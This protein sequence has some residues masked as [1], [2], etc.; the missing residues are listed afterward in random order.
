MELG[1]IRG[2]DEAVD[3]GA[4]A[5]VGEDLDVPAVEGV[6]GQGDEADG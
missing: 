4:G 3:A 6:T 5:L 2:R 1:V